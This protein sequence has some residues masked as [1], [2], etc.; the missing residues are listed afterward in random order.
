MPERT[1]L[2]DPA[3]HTVTP[4][5]LCRGGLAEGQHFRHH[6]KFHCCHACG[7]GRPVIEMPKF[8]CCMKHTSLPDSET[9]PCQRWTG[10]KHRDRAQSRVVV[11]HTTRARAAP[12]PLLCWLHFG[13]SSSACGC[14][15][16]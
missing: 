2:E 10:Q 7:E 11:A 12:P 3:P 14:S 9:N 16:Y 15:I 5:V 4:G 1:T 13:W 8:K 6:Q